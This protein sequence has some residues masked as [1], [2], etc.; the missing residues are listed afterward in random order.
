MKRIRVKYVLLVF[1]LSLNFGGYSQLKKYDLSRNDSALII[2]YNKA[3]E[4]HLNL[5]HK[6]EASRFLNLMATL[7]WEHNH[8]DKAIGLYQKSLELNKALGN[9]NAQAM[10]NS[11]LALIYNDAGKYEQALQYFTK[12]LTVRKVRKEPIG[13]IAA[14][15]NISVV[16]N[17]LKRYDKSIEHLMEALDYARETND[18]TQMRSCYG[19]LSETY[20]KAGDSK[21]SIYYFNL[22]KTFNEMIQQ[23]KVVLIQQEVE[24]ERLKKRLKELELQQ[25]NM[26]IKQKDKELDSTNVELATSKTNEKDLLDSLSTSELKMELLKQ[27]SFVEKL[28]SENELQH[29]ENIITIFLIIG[30]ALLIVLI[31]LIYLFIRN[32]KIN[33]VLKENNFKISQQKQ[34]IDAQNAELQEAYTKVEKAHENIQASINYAQFIQT[35][36]LTKEHKISD[37]VPNSFILF[38]PKN[39]VSGDFYWHAKVGDE[40]VVVAA[41]C[42]G[43]GVPGGFLS[44]LGNNL[45]NTVVINNK[46]TN[47][48]EIL[49]YLDKGVVEVLN[50]KT[51]KNSD[52]MDM[53]IVVI[54]PK[55]KTL[56]YGGAKSP[57]LIVEG[58]KITKINPSRMPIGS[59]NYYVLKKRADFETKLI[60]Y[61]DSMTLYMYSDGYRDQF[62]GKSGKKLGAK[63]MREILSDVSKKEMSEQADALYYEFLKWK[64]KREQI[65][66]LL[67]MGLKLNKIN[68]NF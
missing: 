64:G 19:M 6:K 3:Y 30:I 26:Q 58:E 66:D 38:K 29:R 63:K 54:N 44:M 33:N 36:M 56:R 7:Y 53:A 18:P 34:E 67:F 4:E 49:D 42:T 5:D 60:D 15:I 23:E 14:D 61:N 8:F 17:N 20:E 55:K 28:E 41:D 10:I 2:D 11:N 43:H 65:D 48:A 32:K 47:P 12:T 35:S 50:Q 57:M 21:K 9:E 39:I 37:Y 40:L 62:G 68:M 52:G 22:Y 16:L 25:A 45:L 59:T 1:F 13:I 31:M 46:V 27:K 51:N 24:N